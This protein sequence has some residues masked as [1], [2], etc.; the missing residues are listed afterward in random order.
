MTRKA[1]WTALAE[2]SGD[3]A[4]RVARHCKAASR[5]ACSPNDAGAFFGFVCFVYFAVKPL[6]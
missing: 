5:F 6:S 2:R 3:S 1:F 4:F